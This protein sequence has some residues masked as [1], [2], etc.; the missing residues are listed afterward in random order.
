MVHTR[1]GAAHSPALATAFLRPLMA[2]SPARTLR[3]SALTPLALCLSQAAFAQSTASA[4]P[5]D[6]AAPTVQLQ[7]VRINASTEKDV[8]FAPT[9]AQTAGKAPMRRLETPQSV[10]V[11][12]R[13]QM[14]SRQI[15]N[16]QQ[17][18]QTVA[19]V[20]PVNFGRRGFDDIN[21]RG[22]R[23]TESILIDGL[24]Q[25]SGMWTR[26]TPYG[27]ERFEVLKGA[28]SVLYGQVQ[29]GGIVNAVSKRPKREALSEVGA[30]VGSFGQ[31]TLQ[32]DI[33]RPLNESGKAAIRINAQISNSDDPTDSIYRRDRWIAPSLSLDLGA[34][35]DLV[36]FA[37]YSQSNWMRQ[38]GITPYGTL[39]PNRNGTVRPTLYTG[40][41]AFGHYDIESTSV[42]YALEH[43]FSPQLTL[44]Q[45][46]RYESE[47]GTGNFVSNQTLQSNQRLQNRQ[48]TRQ[49]L[50]DDI[51]A[52]DTSL[53]A[54]FSALAVQHRLV[55]GLD[56][57]TGHSWQGQRRCTIGA[58]DLFN[59]VY[60]VATTCPVGYTANAPEKLSVMGLY[61]Q[62]QIKF[63]PQWTA[64]V[65]IRRD[66]SDNRITDHLAGQAT[67]QKD[68]ATTLSAGLVYEFTPGWAAYASYG[69]SFLP[70]S[71]TS[72]SGSPFA[73]ETGK[74]WETGLKYEAPG[75][76][77]TGSLALFDLKR[78]NVTTADPAN[79]GFSVQTG[80]QRA[81]G[82]ELEMGAEL[83][84]NLKLTGAYT[85]T[86]TEV[87]RDNNAAIVGKPLNLTPRHT[88]ALWATYKLP[89]MPQL[90]LGA[91]LRRVSEQVGSYPFTLPA[92]T[93]ADLSIGYSGTNYRITAG[94]K[95]VFDKAY[96]DGAINANV[97]SPALPRNFSLG[98]TY[99]F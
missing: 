90:T 60:G 75:G 94:V 41:P 80:E 98:L 35:T 89:Q 31:R 38:Q 91:G 24:V 30:E 20:S 29:P 71:G 17:A 26:L 81:R 77:L 16:L 32:A 88:L 28:A 92:Y 97:V 69:E 83:Q 55:T 34:Q 19:G 46:V 84:R 9:E 95:N 61:A 99:F 58:L 54:Q 44:R 70:V 74:Q 85:Y 73:P 4:P 6:P 76:G 36:L 82:L 79:T 43:R 86:D 21:I 48:A 2:R 23:S 11:V 57:R 37:T 3:R 65:G 5:A 87:T 42:G 27:Y 62:D 18:L 14:E 63:D 93:V 25:S 78:R 96:Y 40:D 15:T 7:E 66:W 49:Y 39:L 64:L 67:R 52:T 47:K 50:E 45:N 1:S 22:F 13:E 51:L 72:F 59:P 12:T 10:S 33:N 53:L 8:G 56:A 68:S